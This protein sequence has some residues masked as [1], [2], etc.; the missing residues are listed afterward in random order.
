MKRAAERT[1]GR[2]HGFCELGAFGRTR[3]AGWAPPLVDARGLPQTR[4]RRD[5]RRRRESARG[6][7]ASDWIAARWGPL[8]ARSGPPLSTADSARAGAG[9]IT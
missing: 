8:C 4:R 1:L 2:H 9:G 5:L 6:S 3:R 7:D